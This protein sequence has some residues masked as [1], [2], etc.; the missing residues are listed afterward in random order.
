MLPLFDKYAPYVFA[1]YAVAAVILV[2]LVA[3]PV[4]RI[5]K[6]RRELDAAE[7]E[8]TGEGGAS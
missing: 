7:R 5:R 4:L 1:A 8:Q 6:A 3:W 2:A